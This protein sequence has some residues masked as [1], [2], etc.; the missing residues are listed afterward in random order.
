MKE[1]EHLD[2][3]TTIINRA[4]K[5]AFEFEEIEKMVTNAWE[6]RGI[7]RKY[8]LRTFQ[9]DLNEVAEKFGTEI[10]FNR[11]TKK[12]EINEAESKPINFNIL[13]SFDIIHTFQ[14]SK[15][16][17]NI[18]FFDNQ[19]SSGTAHLSILL[20]ALKNNFYV[21]FK[22]HQDWIESSNL[23]L[24]KPLAL[25]EVKKNWYLVARNESNELR[26]YGLNRLYDVKVKPQKFER[27]PNFDFLAAYKHV[28]GIFNSRDG[29]VQTIVLEF[30]SI[31]GNYIKSKP[32][33]PTQQIL[34]ENEF[35]LKVSLELKI[36]SE[37]ISEILSFGEHV[38]VIGP[39][40]LRTKIR[41]TAYNILKSLE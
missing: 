11:R 38:K 18:V 36:N 6:T 37:L 28:F 32:I 25:K 41:Q 30:S 13:E 14:L 35:G 19:V 40:E 39:E 15:G 31:Q 12:Y 26:N 9:R 20:Y 21:S 4:Q 3:I 7:L 34:E 16:L 23:R 1:F 24:V 29:T 22:H 17:E 10:R 5:D 27:D 33:H 8:T 2:R